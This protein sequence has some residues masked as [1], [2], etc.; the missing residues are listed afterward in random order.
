MQLFI[1]MVYKSY[2]LSYFHSRKNLR[3]MIFY[4]QT[5]FSTSSLTH[6]QLEFGMQQNPYLPFYYSTTLSLSLQRAYTYQVEKG[7]KVEV[8]CGNLQSCGLYLLP[9]RT[10]FSIIL[11]KVNSNTIATYFGIVQKTFLFEKNSI[12]F[13]K[14]SSQ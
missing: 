6:C 7:Q 14:S 1:Y 4:Y 9:Y 13:M 10:K 8:I 3:N 2:T 12:T 5:F 11:P